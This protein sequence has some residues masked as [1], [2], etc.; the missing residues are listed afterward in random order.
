MHIYIW[1]Y[2]IIIISSSSSSSSIQPW[3]SLGRNQSLV[4]WPVWLWYAASWASS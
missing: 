4:G 3:A 1:K 2:I